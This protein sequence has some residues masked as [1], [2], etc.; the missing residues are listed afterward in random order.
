MEVEIEV[1]DGLREG[2]ARPV[3]EKGKLGE[4]GETL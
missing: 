2:R 3:L 1:G 4:L